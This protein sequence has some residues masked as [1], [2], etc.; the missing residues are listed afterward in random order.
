MSEFAVWSRGSGCACGTDHRQGTARAAQARPPVR[1]YVVVLLGGGFTRRHRPYGLAAASCLSH[2]S[3]KTKP[4]RRRGM[5]HGPHVA[6]CTAHAPTAVRRENN[7]HKSCLRPSTG[8]II[9][10]TWQQVTRAPKTA[11]CSCKSAG[12][13]ERLP[14][15]AFPFAECEGTN[16]RRRARDPLATP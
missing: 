8:H 15:R 10:S 14:R 4:A 1:R 3:P 16:P 13:R 11:G 7:V 12:P 2:E 6:T 9:Q 5:R